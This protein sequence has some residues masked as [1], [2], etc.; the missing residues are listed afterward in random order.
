MLRYL[1][2]FKRVI[3]DI[4]QVELSEKDTPSATIEDLKQSAKTGP[5]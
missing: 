4:M 3:R 2:E 1:G 5:G